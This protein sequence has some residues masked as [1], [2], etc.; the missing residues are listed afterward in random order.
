MKTSI[1]ITC[2]VLIVSLLA[3]LGGVAFAS[4]KAIQATKEQAQQIEAIEEQLEDFISEVEEMIEQARQEQLDRQEQYDDLFEGLPD[5]NPGVSLPTLPQ[6]T[7]VLKPPAPEP[8]EE[9]KREFYEKLI[10]EYPA[11]EVNVKNFRVG[12]SST[13]ALINVLAGEERFV[14]SNNTDVVIGDGET[15]LVFRCV[16]TE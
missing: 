11:E 1:K 12:G 10:A 15:Y 9:E 6:S 13:S 7:D 4:I 16:V 14:Y 2:I 5:R 3:M 8:V